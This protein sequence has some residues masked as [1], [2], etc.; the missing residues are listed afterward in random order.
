MPVQDQ[1]AGVRGVRV[2]LGYSQLGRQ[3]PW[4]A[5]P[6]HSPQGG[7]QQSHRRAVA[8]RQVAAAAGAGRGQRVER[9]LQ[10]LRDLL[11]AGDASLGE[12][13]P[14][15]PAVAAC[16][17]V[18]A[19]AGKARAVAGGSVAVVVAQVDLI[20]ADPGQQELSQVAGV[21]HSRAQVLRCL[22][23]QVGLIVVEFPQRDGVVA[24]GIKDELGC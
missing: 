19:R 2:W 12:Q 21:A 18:P 4:P 15:Q 3:G 24:P 23:R 22:D 7:G 8:W 13:R 1:L 20:G 11:L 17:H 14:D 5:R 16:G 6:P 9:A 10:L